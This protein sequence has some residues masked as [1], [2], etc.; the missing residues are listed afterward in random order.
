MKRHVAWI[1]LMI[2]AASVLGLA[3]CSPAAVNTTTTASSPSVSPAQGTSTTPPAT[4]TTNEKPQYGGVLNLAS[5]TDL[6]Y[7]DEVYG[8]GAGIRTTP[9]TNEELVTGDW[10]KGY[11]GGYGTDDTDWSSRAYDIMAQKT[12]GLAASWDIPQ[13]GTVIFHIR[14]GVH[15][16]SNPN[17]KAATLV[18]GAELTAEDIAYQL[19]LYVDNSHAYIH[20]AY[21]GLKS[22]NITATDKYTVLIQCDPKEFADAFQHFGDF[23]NIWPEAAYEKYGDN[24][25]VD[26]HNSVGTGP[27]ILT[28][29]V[30]G[31]DATLIRNPNYWDKDP[32]G[33]GKGSQLPYLDG[34]NLLIISDQ[35][36]LESALRTG[37]IDMYGPF[38]WETGPQLMQQESRLDSLKYVPDT[39]ALNIAMRVDKAPYSDLR[40]RQALSMAIDWQ[41]VIKDYYGGDAYLPTWPIT[42]LKG[43]EPAYLSLDASDCPASVKEM[44]TYN[45]DEAKQLLAE[46]GYP[47][48][49]KTSIIYTASNSDQS[50]Y[51]SIIKGM[52]AKVGVDL[53]LDPRDA[54]VVVNLQASRNYPDMIP[55]FSAPSSS[56]FAAID[57]LGEGRCNTSRVPPNSVTEQALQQMLQY[58]ITDQPKAFA[59]HRELMKYVLAQGWVISSPLGPTYNLWWPWLKNYK[60]EYSVGKD[61]NY[62]FAKWV[63]IDQSLKQKMI[64]SR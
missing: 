16:A 39:G 30:S 52:W 21:P 56:Y 41:E 7:F 45:P 48:G 2:L 62:N 34:I 37:K 9:F 32:I 25:F 3:A 57:Y 53:S 43:Y 28:D 6:L 35:S 23:A 11:A 8:F 58:A 44:F 4:T 59:I 55:E 61:N 1:I 38:N 31:S 51:F 24:V 54:G 10:M 36:T 13:D 40:V 22:A 17:S 20:I 50:N 14:Q 18:G 26:W 42:P 15:W 60:G 64:G 47:N 33:P 49:F 29:F 19:K 5:T 63:W 12:G 46:A 27:F